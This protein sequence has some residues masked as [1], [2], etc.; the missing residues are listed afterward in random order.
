MRRLDGASSS[1]ELER[2]RRDGSVQ[3]M[4]QAFIVPLEQQAGLHSRPLIQ[5]DN[6]L[7]TPLSRTEL[8]YD[9]GRDR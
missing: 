9:P 3:R 7:E 4:V 5:I 2:M 8:W 1:E 6:P